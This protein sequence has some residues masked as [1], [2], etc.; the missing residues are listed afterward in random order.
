MATL[1]DILHSKD[2]YGHNQISAPQLWSGM[3]SV[4]MVLDSKVMMGVMQAA[5]IGGK[6]FYSIPVVLDVLS[7][8]VVS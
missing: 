2:Y 8:S 7:K 4:G 1:T 5:D 3:R 6:G